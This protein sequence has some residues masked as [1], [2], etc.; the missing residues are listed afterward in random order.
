MSYR[1]PTCNSLIHI[2]PGSVE[3][4]CA[5]CW[6]GTNPQQRATWILRLRRANEGTIFTSRDPIASATATVKAY[7][8][9]LEQRLAEK[10]KALSQMPRWMPAKDVPFGSPV[11]AIAYP[12]DFVDARKS[13]EENWGQEDMDTLADEGFADTARV[14]VGEWPPLPKVT[15]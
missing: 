12:N 15:P 5:A 9:L 7:V 3:M 11:L 13:D 4:P 8:A 6:D 1:C 10:E 14:L 2:D